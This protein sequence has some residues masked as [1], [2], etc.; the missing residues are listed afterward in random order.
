M[1]VT[2]HLHDV[3]ATELRESA[4]ANDRSVSAVVAEAIERYLAEERRRRLGNSVL[5]LVGKIKVAP[6]VRTMLDE[7]REDDRP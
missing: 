3:L 5:E 6:D 2:V 7:G 4:E 1:R